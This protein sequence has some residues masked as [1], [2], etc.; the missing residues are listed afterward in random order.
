MLFSCGDLKAP[1]L[2][3]LEREKP[4]FPLHHLSPSEMH[5]LCHLCDNKF[6]KMS[7][8]LAVFAKCTQDAGKGAG[9]RIKW[10]IQHL[11]QR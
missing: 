4:G 2:C 1:D 11:S 9:V 6:R 7:I 8:I 3:F 5:F 10:G